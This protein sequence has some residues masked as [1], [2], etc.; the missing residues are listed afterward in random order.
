MLITPKTRKT[1]HKAVTREP[2]A[3]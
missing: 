2:V 1:Q 3:R